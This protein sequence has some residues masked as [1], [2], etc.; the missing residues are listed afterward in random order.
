VRRR[1][2]AA[3]PVA[4]VNP[5]AETLGRVFA[6]PAELAATWQQVATVVVVELLIAFALVAWEMLARTPGVLPPAAGNVI[7]IMAGDPAKFALA[8]LAPSPGRSLAVGEL[9]A[10][11][12]AWCARQGLR[13][14]GGAEF[15]KQFL[16]LA[17][18]AGV[19]KRQIKGR[20]ICLDLALVA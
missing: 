14:L 7:S 8:C 17:S 9:Y 12:A 18:F 13:A 6:L 2:E 11:Y 20:T 4:K 3:P 5:M 15:E 19:R 16:A 10:H 1:L